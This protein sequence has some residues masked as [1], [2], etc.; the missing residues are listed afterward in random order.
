MIFTIS[1]VVYVSAVGQAITSVA[2]LAL[3]DDAMENCAEWIENRKLALSISVAVMLGFLAT[4]IS[5]NDS[6]HRIL[7]WLRITT[8]T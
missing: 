6:L 4:Y 5:N 2:V 8:E 3:S 1:G 7:R